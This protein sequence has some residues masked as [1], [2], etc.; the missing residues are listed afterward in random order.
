VGTR[1]GGTPKV[2]PPPA[3]VRS[4][5]VSQL[6]SQVAQAVPQRLVSTGGKPGGP[7]VASRRCQVSC[8]T[9]S[10][11]GSRSPLRAFPPRAQRPTGVSTSSLDGQLAMVVASARVVRVD[12]AGDAGGA[13][14]G[15]RGAVGR[16]GGP[17]AVA[18]APRAPEMP[19]PLATG[20]ARGDRIGWRLVRRGTAPSSLA[21]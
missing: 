11:I 17:V 14:D 9:T 6:P 10:R 18:T 12:C 13:R 1:P 21:S 16:D 2:G 19:E 3:C 7:P 8:L 20:S 5:S 4:Y 15:R